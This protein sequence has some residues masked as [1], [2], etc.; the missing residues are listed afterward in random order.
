MVELDSTI[1]DSEFDRFEGRGLRHM[2]VP[3]E[4]ADTIQ[5]GHQ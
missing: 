3:T 4:E 1:I 2:P 5:H